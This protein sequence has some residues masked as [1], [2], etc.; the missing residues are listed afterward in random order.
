MLVLIFSTSIFALYSGGGSSGGGSSRGGPNWP[1][2]VP[3]PNVLPAWPTTSVTGNLSEVLQA[4]FNESGTLQGSN[5]DLIS[6]LVFRYHETIDQTPLRANT[7][8]WGTYRWKI[9]ERWVW[10]PWTGK[11]KLSTC[12]G[13]VDNMIRESPLNTQFGYQGVRIGAYVNLLRKTDIGYYL[14]TN[15][16][17]IPSEDMY[18]G[19]RWTSVSD[20]SVIATFGSSVNITPRSG[21]QNTAPSSESVSCLYTAN[22]SLWSATRSYTS[23]DG[24]STAPLVSARD[25]DF[26]PNSGGSGSTAL[27]PLVLPP[28]SPKYPLYY[29]LPFL[30]PPN[31]A[32]YG[33]QAHVEPFWWSRTPF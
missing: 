21:A 6:I 23:S 10:M 1:S 31:A 4:E 15:G 8:R 2:H 5:P 17:V 32:F 28:N 9:R 19:S 22:G 29:G 13:F 24:T 27:T 25:S 20:Q 7:D 16:T 26:W 11:W 3:F 18:E 30:N 12:S 14:S 33:F